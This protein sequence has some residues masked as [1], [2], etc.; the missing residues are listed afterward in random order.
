MGL[1]KL[2]FGTNRKLRGRPRVCSGTMRKI[3]QWEGVV[4]T[5][6]QLRHSCLVGLLVMVFIGRVLTSVIGE[7]GIKTGK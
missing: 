2:V 5:W 4:P 3:W 1:D 7:F 6:E